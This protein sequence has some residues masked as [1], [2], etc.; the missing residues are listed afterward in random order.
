MPR[1]ARNASIQSAVSTAYELQRNGIK[2]DHH[3]LASVLDNMQR[4]ALREQLKALQ[5]IG[6]L[7]DLLPSGASGAKDRTSR[8]ED[9]PVGYTNG[10]RSERKQRARRGIGNKASAGTS[11]GA[12]QRSKEEVD[13]ELE[14]MLRKGYKGALPE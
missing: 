1:I 14:R 8:D 11:N 10:H 9:N 4:D 7:Q 6:L 5:K 12:R 13:A 3:D 2:K